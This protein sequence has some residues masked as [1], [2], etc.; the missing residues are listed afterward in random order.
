MHSNAL[1]VTKCADPNA[2]AMV[3]FAL[4]KFA[5]RMADPTYPPSV[6]LVAFICALYILVS[7]TTVTECLFSGVSPRP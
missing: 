5:V 7:G 6:M 1:R 3:V 4:S 2:A